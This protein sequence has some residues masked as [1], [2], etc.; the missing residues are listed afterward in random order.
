MP[1]VDLLGIICK[2][3][4]LAEWLEGYIAKLEAKK[5][6][7]EI[8]NAPITKQEELDYWNK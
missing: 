6:T 8:A 2:A 3:L 4:G 7:Q 5:K 1:W